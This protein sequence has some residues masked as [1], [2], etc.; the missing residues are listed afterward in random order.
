M[1]RRS[2]T[3]KV[4]SGVLLIGD[5]VGDCGDLESGGERMQLAYISRLRGMLQDAVT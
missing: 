5:V 4:C 1:A 2:R 3:S